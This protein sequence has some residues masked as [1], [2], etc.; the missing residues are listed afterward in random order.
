MQTRLE[1]KYMKVVNFDPKALTV[2]LETSFRDGEK[3]EK[4]VN[5]YTLKRPDK[6]LSQIMLEIKSKNRIIIDD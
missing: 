1:I 2:E 6:L 4:V 3:Q 5:Q